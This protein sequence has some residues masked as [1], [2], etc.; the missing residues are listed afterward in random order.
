MNGLDQFLKRKETELG[1]KLNDVQTKAVVQTEGPLLLLA[2]PGSGKTTTII[3]RIGYLIEEK[4]ANPSRIKAVTFSRASAR[5]M[6]ERFKRFFPHLPAVDFS[7]IHSLAYE[8][9]REHFRKT[10]TAYHIIEGGT[11]A[12]GATSEELD[13][14]GL[15]LHKRI[16]LR[17]LF[18]EIVG[19]NATDDGMEALTTYISYVKNKMIPPEEWV[20]VKVDVPQ[21]ERILREYEAFKRTGHSKL[22]IDFDDMLTIG[23]DI[24]GRDEF[25]LRKYQR[26]Y[27][28]LLTDES[29]DTSMVQHAIIE[30]LAREHQNLCVVADDDQSIYSW[31]GAEPSY[32]LNF[33]AAYPSAITLYMEQNYRSSQEIVA[34][35]NQ[36]IKRNKNRY[37]KNMFTQ[38]ASV[39][40]VAFKRLAD[41]RSQAKYVAREMQ[42]LDKLSEAAILYRNNSSSIGLMNEFDRAGIPFYMKDADNRFFSHWVIEDILNFMR[43]TFT[44]K[45]PDI[46]ENIH[47]KFNGYISKHQMAVLKTIENNESVFDNLLNIVQLQ[48]YQR[49]PITEAKETFQQMSGMPPQQ[50]IR[51][52][53]SRLGY[54]KA[55][56]K[57]CERLGFSKEYLIGILNTLEDIADG[58]ETMADFANRLKYLEAVLKGAKSR[59]GQNVVTFSTFHSAKGLEFDHVYMVD[60]IE[61]IIP[62]SDETK[63]SEADGTQ[64]LMEEAVRLFYVAMTRARRHLELVAY[65][66]RDGEKKSESS[67]MTAVRDIVDPSRRERKEASALERSKGV[68]SMSV[69]RE[70]SSSG[71]KFKSIT[72]GRVA[73]QAE[74]NPNAIR[75][76]SLLVEGTAVRHRVFGAG[77]IEAM[78]GERVTIRFGTSNVK[79]LAISMCLEMGLLELE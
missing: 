65:E 32:L 54:E 1:V 12:E 77:V 59:R 74:V 76:Q 2:S 43:M 13:E 64:P 37:N 39:E 38:N 30:K 62:S 35:S 9:V 16:I 5:D 26:R 28:Y 7:T 33:K 72:A 4:G 73:K 17:G 56:E 10:G 20:R 47:L 57:M 18:K 52:I 31:R 36:F 79:T 60:L 63:S 8:V 19:E 14:N 50:A 68:S 46:L 71:V 69:M 6:K 24:L 42:K 3:M 53:R 41:Y 21:A 40:E 55:L 58:L 44:D 11:E 66:Q 75:S 51:V 29:Q 34:V 27:D 70:E 67:F 25:V 49:K 45:R 61:G 22:L 48:E 78:D 15:P 23:N